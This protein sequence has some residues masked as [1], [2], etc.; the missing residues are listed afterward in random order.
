M[1]DIGFDSSFIAAEP[2]A[3]LLKDWIRTFTKFLTRTYSDN[4]AE[5]ARLEVATERWTVR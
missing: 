1:F 3:Q 5:M 4:L 2:D